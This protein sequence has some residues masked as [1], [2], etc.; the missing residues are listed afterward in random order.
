[1]I[2]ALPQACAP[3]RVDDQMD[4]R[5]VRRVH[6]PVR[7]PG[8]EDPRFARGHVHL[9]AGALEAHVG[10]RAHGEVHAEVVAPVVVG[11]DVGGELALLLDAHEP[12]T[13]DDRIE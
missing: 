3:H 11:V 6:D 4:A 10:R 5:R 1:M 12:G 13:A 7:T 9:V 8:V 2:D